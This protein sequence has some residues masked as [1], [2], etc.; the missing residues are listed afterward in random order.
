MS[1]HND[2]QGR[3]RRRYPRLQRPVFYRVPSFFDRWKSVCDVGLGGCRIYSDEEMKHGKQIILEVLL[4][5]GT[6]VRVRARVVWTATMAEGSAAKYE[7]GLEFMSVPDESWD[8][9]KE[10]LET[11]T[12]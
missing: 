5:D 1:S 4:P 12:G 10:Y 11:P 7:I 6:T 9:L 8:V 3:E 2:S